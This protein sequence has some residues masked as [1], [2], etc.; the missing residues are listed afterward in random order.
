MGDARPLSI[1]RHHES[2]NRSNGIRGRRMSGT[3]R[4]D[5]AIRKCCFH[6][7]NGVTDQVPALVIFSIVQGAP[8]HRSI[9]HQ[10]DA[11]RC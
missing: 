4:A 9:A 11:I 2:K 5:A 1:A 10:R 6:V 7:A 3:S 8:T